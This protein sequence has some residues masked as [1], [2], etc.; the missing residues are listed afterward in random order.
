MRARVRWDLITGTAVGIK[1]AMAVSGAVLSGWVFLHM[2]GNLLVFADPSVINGYGATLQGS[3]L[4]W[5]MR[6]GL[7][8]ALGVHVWGAVV[9]TRR[10]RTAR[11]SRYRRALASQTS[12]PA[13]RVMSSLR[14]NGFDIVLLRLERV[15]PGELER[16][17]PRADRPRHFGA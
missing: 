1:A 10:A 9:T 2:L 11:P 7:T 6:V 3:P 17:R 4:V 14:S 12:T 5:L 16:G 13:S 15:H 8:V